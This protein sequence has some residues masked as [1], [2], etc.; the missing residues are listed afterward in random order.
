SKNSQD[1]TRVATAWYDANE[2]VFNVAI[3]S[4]QLKQIALY[5]LD[6]DGGDRAEDVVINDMAGAVLMSRRLDNFQ[7]GK[8][9][10][11]SARGLFQIHVRHLSG[12]N[13]VLS[14]IFFGNSVP[15]SSEPPKLD[16]PFLNTATGVYVLRMNGQPGQ[17]FNMQTSIDLLVWTV[18]GQATFSK[19]TFDWNIPV[20]QLVEKTFYRAIAA[21]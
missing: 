15:V 4:S 18:V 14:G 11:L 16:P 20:T 5:F 2:C 1:P 12:P 8:Y 6:W 19:T 7:L 13:A 9:L 17:T 3:Y 21:P 10:V